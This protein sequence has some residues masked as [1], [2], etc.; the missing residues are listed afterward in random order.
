MNN[1]RRLPAEWEPQDGVLL[2]WPHEESDWHPYLEAV[3]PVFAQIIAQVSRFET[4]IVAAPEPEAVRGKL[5]FAGADPERVRIC[6]VETNDTWARDFGPITVQEEGAVK[7][8]NFGFN[9]WGL[10][11]PS[12]LDNRINK[13]LQALGVWGAALETVV[14]ELTR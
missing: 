11:F 9:G 10:K 1:S 4:A 2:A 14:E 8:L 7:L 6:Q 12:D 3:E 13:K 5:L